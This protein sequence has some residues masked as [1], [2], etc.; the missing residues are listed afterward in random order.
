MQAAGPP[1]EP[2]KAEPEERNMHPGPQDGPRIIY[3]TSA[4]RGIP[5]G[6]WSTFWSFAYPS[7]L[8]SQY[9]LDEYTLDA[10]GSRGSPQRAWYN[11]SMG[12]AARR[13][14]MAM[15]PGAAPEAR[16]RADTAERAPHTEVAD[17]ME[18]VDTMEAVD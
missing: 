16:I 7:E 1:R 15:G 12:I 10:A 4:S 17:A 13:S 3:Q 2:P 14:I 6:L 8:V 9:T 18:A 11:S 5:L